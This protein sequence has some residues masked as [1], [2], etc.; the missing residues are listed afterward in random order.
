MKKPLFLAVVLTLALALLAVGVLRIFSGGAADGDRTAARARLENA[1]SSLDAYEIDAV[2]K[3]D[4]N[5]LVVTQTLRFTNTTGST[6][7]TIAL[8]F[9][10]GAYASD[11]TSPA[12]TTELFDASYGDTFSAGNVTLAG[13][14]W[15]DKVTTAAF[16]DDAQTVLTV[17]ADSAPGETGVLLLRFTLSIPECAHYFGVTDGTYRFLNVLPVLAMYENG[18]WNTDEFS[19]VGEPFY[20]QCAN[21]TFALTVP[22]GYLAASSAPLT[23]E[24]GRYRGSINAARGFS[25]VVYPKAVC[26]KGESRGVALT[27]FAAT[28]AEAD[29]ALQYVSNALTRLTTLYGAAPYD[30]LTVCALSLS[31]GGFSAPGLI[32]YDKDQVKDDYQAE[33]LLARLAAKQWFTVMVGT[34][35]FSNAWQN[36]APAEWAMLQYVKAVYGQD[37]MTALRRFRVDEPMKENIASS[38]TPGSPTDYFSGQTEYDTVVRGRGTA[39]LVAADEMLSGRLNEFLKSLCA[40]HAFQNVSRAEFEEALNSFASMDISPLMLDYLDTYMRN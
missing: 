6:L 34:D 28:K 2:L 1:A 38:V 37:S 19:S 13:A 25:F 5:A 22:T 12:A 9:Y 32:V 7:N 24:N 16:S 40:E 15:N 27:A 3:P 35:G 36:E 26:A 23:L 33:I 31:R 21:Y 8:R 17:K 30:S 18:A 14:W 20:A 10:A 29:R 4:E 39:F 11:E